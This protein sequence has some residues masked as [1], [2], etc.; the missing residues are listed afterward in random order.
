MSE[1]VNRIDNSYERFQRINLKSTDT[2]SK[3]SDASKKLLEEEKKALIEEIAKMKED[4]AAA[5]NAKSEFLSV[6]SHEIRTPMNAI[7]GMSGLLTDTILSTE[8]KEYVDT[9]RSSGDKLLTLINDI[10]DFTEI[11]SGKL[12]LEHQPFSLRNCVSDAVG[13]ISNNALAKSLDVI[14]YVDPQVP[15]NIF[16][17]VTRLR[18]VIVN[19]LNNAVKF[20]NQ[21]DVFL[22]VVKIDKTHKN[23]E[24]IELEFSI[25]DTGIGIKNTEAEKIFKEFSQ[26]DSSLTRKFGGAGLGLAICKKLL[27]MMGGKIWFESKEGLGTTF[28]FTISV[29]K[30]ELTEVK[31]YLLT[32]IPNLKDKNLLII[33]ENRVLRQIISLQTQT[34]GMKPKTTSS[35][36][37]AIDWLKKYKFDAV[38]LDLV[39]N[40]KYN[41]EIV[42]EIRKIKGDDFPILALKRSKTNSFKQ[43]EMFT[44]SV[45]KPVN[46]Q[47]LF[48]VFNLVCTTNKAPVIKPETTEKTLSEKL[49]L[50][51]LIAEDNIIN[52]KIASRILAQMGYNADVAGDGLEVLECLSRQHYDL[53]LMDV[54]MPMLDGIQTTGRILEKWIPAERPKIIAM[55]A[56]ATQGDME[57]C[58]NAGMDDFISKPIL[59]D[60]LKSMLE[61][62]GSNPI[63]KVTG[64][65]AFSN[66]DLIDSETVSNLKQITGIDN[67]SFLK[68]V[69]NLYSKQTP[70]LISDIKKHWK[71]NEIQKLILCVHNLRGSSIN[72]GAKMIQEM[73]KNI[74]A[75]CRKGDMGEIENDI[76]KLEYVYQRTINEYKKLV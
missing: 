34:W 49:P 76:E 70:Q 37:E 15:E 55:T 29:K 50:K 14:Y 52:Q 41:G 23:L 65:I 51:I 63:T 21:G 18:Q 8:Q 72:M 38:L 74:E 60:E 1:I 58:M 12:A 28:Y 32:D 26:G 2:A 39:L 27:D 40:E 16:G 31:N 47:E 20:T 44:A 48:E 53:V 22:S 19:L 54:Q 56:N 17:D 66:N 6:I 57:N 7:I 45:T 13:L 25:R 64:A 59:S 73:S 35:G 24:D 75:K 11:D 3:D 42:R 69:V 61:K 30:S 10:L 4:L 46:Q 9:I 43:Q 36:Y 62:W 68:E 5:V 71:D 67:L 33:D